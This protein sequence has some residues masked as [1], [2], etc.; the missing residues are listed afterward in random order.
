MARRVTEMNDNGRIV[1]YTPTRSQRKSL[2]R[3]IPLTPAP[4]TR[5]EEFKRKAWG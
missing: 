2:Q 3:L 4:K 5:W 1:S